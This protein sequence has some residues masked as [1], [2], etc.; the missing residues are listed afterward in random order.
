MR[1]SLI[2]T[3]GVVVLGIG[4]T[5]GILLAQSSPPQEDSGV[6]V[7]PL[8]IVDLVGQPDAESTRIL[9]PRRTTIRPGGASALHNPAA[10]RG[11]LFTVQGTIEFHQ[12]GQDVELHTGQGY[13]YRKDAP[14][15]FENRG[16]DPAILITVDAMDVTQRNREYFVSILRYAVLGLGLLVVILVLVALIV[17]VLVVRRWY[18][19]GVT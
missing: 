4:M 19:K 18:P 10:G 17:A 2:A 5:A 11:V 16:S 12:N 14:Y 1:P 9:Q 8:R 15:W 3:L 6:E 13:P 7:E